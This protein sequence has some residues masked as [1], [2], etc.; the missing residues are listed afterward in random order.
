MVRGWR[1]AATESAELTPAVGPVEEADKQW[2]EERV[3]WVLS[4]RLRL[5]L[6]FSLYLLLSQTFVSVTRLPWLLRL[7]LR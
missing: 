2:P 4:R 5:S 7:L 3:R 1:G 6:R